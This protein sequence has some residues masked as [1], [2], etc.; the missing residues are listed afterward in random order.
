MSTKRV[1]HGSPLGLF[2]RSSQ[3][4]LGEDVSCRRAFE[5]GLVRASRFGTGRDLNLFALRFGKL[6]DDD[7]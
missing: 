7:R 1:V 6:G 4:R 2:V 3:R 5:L